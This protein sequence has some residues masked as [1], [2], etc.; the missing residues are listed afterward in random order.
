MGK[1]E[2][3]VGKKSDVMRFRGGLPV[4][5]TSSCDRTSLVGRDLSMGLMGE[6]GDRPTLIVPMGDGR[7]LVIEHINDAASEQGNRSML[8]INLRARPEEDQT[9]LGLIEVR[10]DDE[11]LQQEI[12]TIMNDNSGPTVT[13]Q[14]GNSDELNVASTRPNVRNVEI[15]L[16]TEV[17]D[18]DKR[19]ALEVRLMNGIREIFRRV[20]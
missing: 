18:K 9:D 20:V 16:P 8:H 13:S 11:G 14:V 5:L 15:T 19:D 17:H 10:S 3:E 2:S 7:K 12:A 1:K 6:F 4:I